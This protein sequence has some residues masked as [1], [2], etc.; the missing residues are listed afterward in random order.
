ML[1]DK[2][3]HQSTKND[4]DLEEEGGKVLGDSHSMCYRQPTSHG[5]F[6]KDGVPSREVGHPEIVFDRPAPQLYSG[7]N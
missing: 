3:K 6:M 1:E 5:Y 4:P 7:D 2:F